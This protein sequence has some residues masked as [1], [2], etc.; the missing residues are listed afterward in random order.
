MGSQITWKKPVNVNTMQICGRREPVIG[1][2]KREKKWPTTEADRC[3]NCS[4]CQT[5]GEICAQT[6]PT[7]DAGDTDAAAERCNFANG[8]EK[9]QEVACTTNEHAD[10]KE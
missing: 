10:E 3:R 7:V 8:C 6:A 2:A 4:V 5:D 1:N 9:G